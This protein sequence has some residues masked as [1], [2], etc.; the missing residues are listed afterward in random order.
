MFKRHKTQSFITLILLLLTDVLILWASAGSWQRTSGALLLLILPGLLLSEI[1]LPTIN[2]V[3]RWVIGL[4]LGYVTLIITGLCLHYLPGPL[5]LT[6]VLLT[7][8]GLS[9]ILLGWQVFQPAQGRHDLLD[10]AE[11]FISA[12]S[13]E[14][15]RQ[16][17]NLSRIFPPIS[18]DTLLILFLILGIAVLFRFPR[19]GYSE[20]QN[21]EVR[22]MFRTAEVLVGESDALFQRQKGPAEVLLPALLW[23]LSG[24]ITEWIARLP[25]ALAGLLA[26]VTLFGFS[27]RYLSI[28]VGWVATSLLAFTGFMVAFSRIVQYQTVVIWMSLLAL[29]AAFAWRE[30]LQQRWAMLSALFLATGFL[31]HYDAILVAPA[32]AYLALFSSV[33]ISTRKRWQTWTLAGAGFFLA[34]GLFY[35][36]YLLAPSA[37]DNATYLLAR[38]WQDTLLKNNL[39]QFLDYNVIYNS[40]YFIFV[41][42]LLLL[43]WLAS[44]LQGVPLVG[45]RFGGQYWLPLVAVSAVLIA[46]IRPDFFQVARF[47]WTPLVFGLIA[48]AALFS[49]RLDESWRA[50][51]LWFVIPFWGYTFIVALPGTH[52]YIFYPALALLAGFAVVRLWQIY[53]SLG[54]GMI[55]GIAGISL[56][57]LVSDHL[58]TAYLR[59]DIEYIQDWPEGHPTSFWPYYEP[60]LPD[61]GDLFGFVHRA[62]WKVVGGLYAE[63][64]LS[65]TYGSNERGSMALWYLRFAPFVNVLEFQ[66]CQKRPDYFFFVDDVLRAE[67]VDPHL[68]ETYY[69]PMGQIAM[70]YDE[71]LSIYQRQ[72]ATQPLGPIDKAALTQRFDQTATPDAFAQRPESHTVG[73]DFG[74]KLRLVE[75]ELNPYQ[76]QPGGQITVRLMWQAAISLE[77]DYHVRLQLRNGPYSIS[78]VEERPCFLYPTNQWTPSQIVPGWHALSIDPNAK[79]ADYTLSVT[80]LIPTDNPDSNGDVNLDMLELQ[81]L[82]IRP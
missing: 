5:S 82:T 49:S 81:T 74:S 39:S 24:T 12:Q 31:A 72:P 23:R 71:L 53:P 47:D 27:R 11:K 77:D 66:I 79:P 10:N 43:G 61:S 15:G 13:S 7:F 36:P 64:R 44:I 29:W 70:P 42:G 56:A 16:K 30:T 62:G 76:P 73:Y 45:R 25:F 1:L 14:V 34:A 17:S 2:R 35:I 59:K 40:F 48:L 50:I 58:Y 41:V 54:M 80:L 26:L 65:G 68:L 6:I 46:F 57:V 75:Y 67:P 4:G 28:P 21:D 38:I 69:A 19:L 63:G 32:I 33:P 3:E 55:L 8:N 22:V 60:Q 78:Q 9:L 20:F 37:D 52:Y 51:T 18:S